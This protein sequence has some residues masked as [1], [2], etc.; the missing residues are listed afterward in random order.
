M[1]TYKDIQ[2]AT[3]LSLSTISKYYNGRTVLD[4]NRAAIEEAAERL[5]FRINGFARNLRARRSR[6]VG[7][8]LPELDNDFHL[9]IIAGVE[10]ALGGEGVSVLVSSSHAGGRPR[11]DA[12]DLMMSK[13]VDGIIAVPSANVVDALRGVAD[14]GVPV[15]MVDWVVDRL[16]ADAV[17]LDNVGAGA[18]AARHLA[19]H[20]HRRIA[21]VGGLE[22]ISTMRERAAGFESALADRGLSPADVLVSSGPLTVDSGHAAMQAFLALRDRPTAVFCANYELTLG[23]LI[24]LNESG[25]RIPNDMSFIGFDSTELAQVARPPLTVVIQP[26]EAIAREAA[27]LMSARLSGEQNDSWEPS[28]VTLPGRL[29]IGGS[30]ASLHSS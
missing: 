13:M 20:G 12:V 11:N 8:L 9:S 14:R 19:D 22:D 4:E 29:V 23:A 21:M 26:L 15:V 28:V 3:G 5:G 16:T 17:V 30:V 27:A 18:M 1:A 10:Q 24:A 25:L 6:T 7:V 2:Q